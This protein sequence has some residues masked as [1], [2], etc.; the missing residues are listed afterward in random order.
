[1][2]VRAVS[3]SGGGEW[4]A[5]RVVSSKEGMAGSE[6]GEAGGFDGAGGWH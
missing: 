5:V 6:G 2:A 4:V 1:M 3:G